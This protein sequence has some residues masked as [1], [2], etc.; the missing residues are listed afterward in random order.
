MRDQPQSAL[1]RA[2]WWTEHVLRHGGGRHLRARAAN[3]SWA[4]YL[5]VE[6]LTV[7][8]LSALAIAYH[9]VVGYHPKG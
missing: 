9:M 5:D 7:L 2:V 8:A 6:L 3:M 1:E 4:E